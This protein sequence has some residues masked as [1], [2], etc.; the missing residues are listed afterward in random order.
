M[1]TIKS[2]VYVLVNNS[3]ISYGKDLTLEDEK[4]LWVAYVREVRSFLGSE[5]TPTYSL[6][7]WMYW[8][9]QLPDGAEDYH[10]E[11]ELVAS[12]W[13]DIIDIETV[14]NTVDVTYWYELYK[15]PE[16]RYW[17]QTF[18]FERKTLSVSVRVI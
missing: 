3:S 14:S 4:S 2:G 6:V 7:D 9:H 10:G 18:Y 13:Q 8:P 12:T 11:Q 5:P 17:R 1:M 15:V 16:G